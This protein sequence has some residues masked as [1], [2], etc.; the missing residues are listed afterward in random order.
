[1]PT[2]RLEGHFDG[3][4]VVPRRSVDLPA[5]T[6]VI[7]TVGEEEDK[8]VW[9]RTAELADEMPGDH[10]SDDRH[11]QSDQ[12]RSRTQAQT[13]KNSVLSRNETAAEIP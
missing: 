9:Q 12:H 4:V 1:M 3:K 2:I 11:D 10:L 6:D 13:R 7:V 8:P 5:G